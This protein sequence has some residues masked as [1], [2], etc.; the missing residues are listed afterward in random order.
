LLGKIRKK[1]R[2]ITVEVFSAP[3]KCS[4]KDF[5]RLTKTRDAFMRA[6][7]RLLKEKLR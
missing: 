2:V 6:I 7:S 3:D 4:A 1:L 5:E